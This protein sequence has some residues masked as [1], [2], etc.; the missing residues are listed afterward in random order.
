MLL[1][2]TVARP[3]SLLGQRLALRSSERWFAARYQ[4]APVGE[5]GAGQARRV[6]VSVQNTGELGWPQGG[7]DAVHLSY[8]WETP[9]GILVEYDGLRTRLP[10]DVAPGAT[11]A[12]DAVVRAPAVPGS[13]RLRWDLVRETVTWFSERGTPTA[14]E[15]VTVVGVAAAGPTPTGGT[16]DERGA[17][18]TPSRPE[19]WRAAVRLWRRHPVL[20]VGP[21]NF[22]HLYAAV[23][24][25]APGVRLFLDERLHAN[26][27]YLETLADLGLAGVA[28]LALLGRELAR[29]LWRGRRDPLARAAAVGAVTF[30]VHGLVDTFGTFTPTL[31]LGWLLLALT[32]PPDT[33]PSAPAPS[34]P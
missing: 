15:L 3:G 29:A 8:H 12:L 25:P 31:V 18:P 33:A 23:I 30:F 1:A 5:L 27:L 13:Y 28:A 22:R 4:A 17:R 24:E 6:R 16:L 14:D 34:P 19:L 11:V 9:A 26:S 21:D 7:H 32:G 10:G 20:G 2:V